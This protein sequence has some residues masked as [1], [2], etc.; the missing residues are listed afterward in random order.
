[1]LSDVPAAPTDDTEANKVICT[2]IRITRI[3]IS[4]IEPVSVHEHERRTTI[5]EIGVALSILTNFQAA[6]LIDLQNELA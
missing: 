1:M 6:F 5:A 2:P 3:V 4:S